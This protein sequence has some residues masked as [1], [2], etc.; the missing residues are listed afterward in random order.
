MKR[1]FFVLALALFATA[2]SAAEILNVSYDVARELFDAVNPAFQQ[3]WQAKGGESVTIRQSHGGS[4]KQARS[5]LDGLPADIVTL[6]QV[7]DVQMLERAGYVAADWR[8]RLPHD[9]S[10]YYS[11]P[12]FLVR[13]G[14]PQQIRDW[15]DLAKPNVKVVFPNPKTSG[16]G[17][18]TYLGA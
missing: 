9:A 10:P 5:V 7:T 8:K 18:Y 4:S 3:A 16:N 1:P 13:A 6:N 11:L 15:S 12:I 14:N 2:A 17:R